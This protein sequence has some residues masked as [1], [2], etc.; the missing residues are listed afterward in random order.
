MVLF[1]ETSVPQIA[2]CKPISMVSSVPKSSNM[3][4]AC[5][6][7]KRERLD[8][9]TVEQKLQRRKLK[10]RVS[11][12]TARDRKKAKI[13][14]LESKFSVSISE[15]MKVR[16]ENELLRR[17]FEQ[18]EAENEKLKM[19]LECATS[20]GKD[21][22]C[23]SV[24]SAELINDSPL[25]RQELGNASILL[26]RPFICLFITM[27][28]SAMRSSD[29]YKNVVKICLMQELIRRKISQ[30]QNPVEA[31]RLLKHL[32]AKAKLKETWKQS[33]T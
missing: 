31:L 13:T 26:M 28:R 9:L 32:L 17:K 8:H 14:D 16:R 18:L 5:L 29:G 24:E 1:T 33:K 23:N 15:V 3:D 19:Q 22:F 20:K 25:K 7:R 4:Q 30:N 21:A 10:N 6:K 27:I 11:A 12:Q 2:A